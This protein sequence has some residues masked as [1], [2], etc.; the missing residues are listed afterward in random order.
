[1]WHYLLFTKLDVDS[2][3]A[4]ELKIEGTGCLK[5]DE[6]MTFLDN[7]VR[8]MERLNDPIH[9][10]QLHVTGRDERSKQG[11][12]HPCVVTQCKESH[13]L[14]AC[15]K[16]KDLSAKDK[17]SAIAASKSCQNCLR[18]NHESDQCS[19]QSRCKTC[20]GKHR[21]FLHE[22]FNDTPGTHACNLTQ[23]SSQMT[24]LPTAR[25]QVIGRNKQIHNLRAMLDT[26]AH[27]N[28]VKSKAWKTLGLEPKPSNERILGVNQKD[29]MPVNKL[30]PKRGKILLSTA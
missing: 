18:F 10:K 15:S 12:K 20:Q 8:S 1:M 2:Q 24:I 27:I 5:F 25:V 16:F 26:G 22:A 7:R 29:S 21:T 14:W 19:S 6:L 3:K 11:F 4:W 23:K 9:P 28:A 13:A 17:Q 30:F